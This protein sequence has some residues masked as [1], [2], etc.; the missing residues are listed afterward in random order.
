[1][2][3][4]LRN[5]PDQD[6]ERGVPFSSRSTRACYQVGAERFGWSQRNPRPRSMRDGHWLIGW[7]MATATYPMLRFPASARARLL[8]D[9]SAVAAPA[10]GDRGPGRYPSLPQVASETLGLPPERVRVVIG[11]SRLPAVPPHGGSMTMASVGSAVQA[12]CVKVRDDLLEFTHE[13]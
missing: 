7:G 11:D 6:E 10:A 13:P 1:V 4:R 9:G 2:E 5:E 3:L 8:A 12:A